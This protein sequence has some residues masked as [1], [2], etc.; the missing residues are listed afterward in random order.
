MTTGRRV[1]VIGDVGGYVSHL[2]HALG[3]LGVTSSTWPDDLEVIQLGDLF[4]GRDDIAVA[5]L[6]GPHLAAGRWTQLVGNWELEAVGGP[7]VFNAKGRTADPDAL[8]TF[9]RWADNGAVRWATTVT[10]AKGAVGVVTHAGISHGFWSRDLAGCRDPVQV[11]ER[12]NSMPLDQVA[13]PGEMCGR[14]TERAPGPVWASCAELW[15]SWTVS[16]FAQ[17]H[18]HTSSWNAWKNQW[19]TR[20]PPEALDR[21]RHDRGHVTFRPSSTS[22]PIVGIDPGLWDRSRPGALRPLVFASPPHP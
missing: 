1:A 9:A 8:Q 22:P 18:G 7:Q 14:P 10:S 21:A 12:I 4:G 17:I 20:T 11:V 16:P 19:N 3:S 6:V 5:E 2:E 15:A 13:R